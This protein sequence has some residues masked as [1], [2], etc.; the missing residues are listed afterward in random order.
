MISKERNTR[1]IENHQAGVF[2]RENALNLV[3]CYLWLTQVISIR[4]TFKVRLKI[5][6]RRR[7]VLDLVSQGAITHFHMNLKIVIA[8]PPV[9]LLHTAH[10][11]QA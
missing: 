10:V 11:Y 5:K 2:G 6:K 1:G 8:L 4:S 3:P 7:V 9:E